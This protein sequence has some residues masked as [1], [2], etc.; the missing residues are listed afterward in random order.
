MKR[1]SLVESELQSFATATRRGDTLDMHYLGVLPDPRDE[2]MRALIE[3]GRERYIR[4]DQV[5]SSLIK[6]S[7]L[8]LP[9]QDAPA[10]SLLALMR[11]LWCR[12]MHSGATTPI[13][14]RYR[15]TRCWIEFEGPYL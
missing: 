7:L 14:G 9:S 2:D 6:A 10:R 1:L 8:V 5:S 4:P 13:H 11:R 3:I 15:C 12:L